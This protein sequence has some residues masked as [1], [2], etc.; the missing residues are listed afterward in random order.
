MS[1]EIH[2]LEAL[3]AFRSCGTLSR[4]AAQLHISQP[5]LSRSMKK[6]EEDLG[7]TLFKRTANRLYLTETGTL[8]ADYADRILALQDEIGSV[9]KNHERSLHTLAI[10]ASAPMPLLIYPASMSQT[11]PQMTITTELVPDEKQLVSQ[12]KKEEFHLIFTSQPVNDPECVSF[13][14]GKEHLYISVIPA[15]PASLYRDKGVTFADMDGE[16]FLMNRNIGIWDA[17]VRKYMPHSRYILQADM[18]SLDMVVNASTLPTFS[19]DLAM[20][21]FPG[22]NRK[23]IAIPF[24][25]ESATM[26]FYGTCLTKNSERLESWLKTCGDWDD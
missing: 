16:T 15:H 4:A 17:L 25:D 24:T 23:R 13:L 18:E 8:A 20:R 7:V 14:C 3:S 26:N 21:V 9:L 10:G 6:L 5:A 1:I 12:L 22:R 19:T 2:L 11:Y